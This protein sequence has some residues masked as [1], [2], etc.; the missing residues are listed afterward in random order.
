[1]LR[2]GAACINGTVQAGA[3]IPVG[4]DPLAGLLGAVQVY[5]QRQVI[6]TGQ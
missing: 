5:E 3:P 1:M 6:C 2:W 4:G